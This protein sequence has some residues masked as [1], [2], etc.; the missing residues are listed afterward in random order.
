MRTV[1]RIDIAGHAASAN[2]THIESKDCVRGEIIV[3]SQV[4]QGSKFF[5]PATGTPNISKRFF[6]KR[7]ATGIP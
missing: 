5:V 3:Q 6:L 2:M 7:S 1:L 4:K